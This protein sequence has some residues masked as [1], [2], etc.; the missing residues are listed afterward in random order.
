MAVSIEDI[1]IARAQRDEANRIGVTP[2]ALLGASLGAT[3][4][5]RAIAPSS[6]DRLVNQLDNFSAKKKK[7]KKGKAAQRMTGK[8]RAGKRMAGGLVGAILGGGLGAGTR[9]AMI[10]NSPA[11]DML[12]KLQVG[13]ELSYSEERALEGM[14]ANSYSNSSTLA[15]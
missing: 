6:T 8:S 5:Y 2:M 12:A 7:K 13:S 15:M 4:G 11:A 14:L 1:L 9:Q 3:A 10:K